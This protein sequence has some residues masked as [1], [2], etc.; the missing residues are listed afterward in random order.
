MALRP[1]TSSDPIKR[2]LCDAIK[3]LTGATAVTMV[4]RDTKT[5]DRFLA[6]AFVK[7]RGGE[8]FGHVIVDTGAPGAR[9]VGYCLD[10]AHYKGGACFPTIEVLRSF[11][12]DA[13]TL[14]GC[15]ERDMKAAGIG[16][17]SAE[18]SA[19]RDEMIRARDRQEEARSVAIPDPN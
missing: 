3:R 16:F 9:I 12:R 11:Q 13:R 14:H 10:E 19:R 8:S 15:F 1:V 18:Y 5:P 17:G 6:H 2:P 4:K 7:R